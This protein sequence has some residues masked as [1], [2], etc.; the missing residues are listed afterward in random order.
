MN[1]IKDRKRPSV[2]PGRIK[3]SQAILSLL[4]KKS[5]DSITWAEIAETAGVNE[6][7][8]YKYFKG[9]RN[10]LHEVLHEYDEGFLKIIRLDQQNAEG[11]FNKIRAFISSTLHYYQESPVLAK[12]LIIEV[13]NYPAYF[14]SETYKQIQEYS[15]ILLRIIEEGVRRGE[16]RTD[17]SPSHVRLMIHGVI[18]HMCLP[19]VIFGTKVNIEQYTDEICK[20][21]FSGIVEQ[22]GSDGEG[23][24]VE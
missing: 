23:S 16:I 19:K 4:K 2:P 20:L 7:L 24:S 15:N 11:T 5:F 10:L 17:I 14:Q 13:R 1:K 3:I 6:G 8:I 18:E 12:I 22:A 9:K 21:V